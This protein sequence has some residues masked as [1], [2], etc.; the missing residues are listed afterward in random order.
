RVAIGRVFQQD[1]SQYI[2][3]PLICYL[4]FL[5][6]LSLKKPLLE[7]LFSFLVVTSATNVMDGFSGYLKTTRDF[8]DEKHR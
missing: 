7:P 6:V 8:N 1:Q 5:T 2:V 3:R 4:L